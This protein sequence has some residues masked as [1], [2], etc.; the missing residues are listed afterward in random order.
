MTT[1]IEFTDSLRQLADFYETCQDIPLPVLPVQFN[2]FAHDAAELMRLRRLLGSTEKR[3]SGDWLFFV[4]KFGQV[5]LH[6]NVSKEKTCK[7]VQVGE[8]VIPAMPARG[9]IEEKREPIY[10]W[11]CDEPLLSHGEEKT[12]AAELIGMRDLEP[13]GGSNDHQN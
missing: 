2:I 9:P 4:R 6:V 11:V 5:E 10:D 12:A 1:R 7:R 3:S 8:R 13:V